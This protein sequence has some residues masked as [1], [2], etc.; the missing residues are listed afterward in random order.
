MAVTETKE[1]GVLDVLQELKTSEAVQ[2]ELAELL[3]S[4]KGTAHEH[5]VFYDL[6]FKR[7]SLEPIPGRTMWLFTL[8]DDQIR[9]VAPVM[10]RDLKTIA[11]KKAKPLYQLH[12]DHTGPLIKKLPASIPWC[13]DKGWLKSERL[14]PDAVWS[15]F[16]SSWSE[17]DLDKI[18]DY[19]TDVTTR[20]AGLEFLQLVEQL[21][22]GRFNTSR[23][24]AGTSVAGYFLEQMAAG[25]KV[26]R[27]YEPVIG[28][29]EF[30]L[31]AHEKG[32][33]QTRDLKACLTQG[34]HN[35]ERY[36]QGLCEMTTIQYEAYGSI[37]AV[38][39]DA[40][41]FFAYLAGLKQTKFPGELGRK[42]GT[43]GQEE[44]TSA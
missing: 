34:T 43:Y 25:Q 39:G 30:L 21:Q 33:I 24:G 40:M 14:S 41:Q 20:V 42:I 38:E 23:A 1:M 44:E 19:G 5:K 29:L 2:G 11:T 31:L 37:D 3:I 16:T 12:N 26:Y 4:K 28:V 27:G 32:L 15:I 35:Y 36:Y 13:M 7:Y 6:I 10:I 18:Q 8:S 9:V 17:D 22:V